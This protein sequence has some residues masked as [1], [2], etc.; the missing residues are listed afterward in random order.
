MNLFVKLKLDELNNVLNDL[1]FNRH[2]AEQSD[3]ACFCEHDGICIYF[4]N[5]GSTRKSTAW[6]AL[7]PCALKPWWLFLKPS[8]INPLRKK[9]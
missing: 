4:T 7:A 1:P 6:R 2:Q 9:K 3:I 8:R 5:A